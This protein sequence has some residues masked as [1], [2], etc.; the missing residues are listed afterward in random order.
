MHLRVA[1]QNQDTGCT[2]PQIV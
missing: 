1:P 2:E